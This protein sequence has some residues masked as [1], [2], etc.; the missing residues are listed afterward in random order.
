[1]SI[2]PSAQTLADLLNDPEIPREAKPEWM[3]RRSHKAVH[4]DDPEGDFLKVVD[5]RGYSVFS[6]YHKEAH[7]DVFWSISAWMW[8]RGHTPMVMPHT[9]R[10]FGAVVPTDLDA[11]VEAASPVEALAAVVKR[12]NAAKPAQ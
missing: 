9:N 3:K 4:V 12:V 11:R 5:K 2:I 6:L 1:M 8:E 10:R 7:R